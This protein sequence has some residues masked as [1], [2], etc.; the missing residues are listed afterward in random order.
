M[1]VYLI[2]SK[3]TDP[4]LLEEIISH[5]MK[6]SQTTVQMSSNIVNLFQKNWTEH[7]LIFF[8]TPYKWK[9]IYL[10]MDLALKITV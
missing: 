8:S 10:I 4:N 7:K 6:S 9:Y 2:S 5:T 3:I 1:L